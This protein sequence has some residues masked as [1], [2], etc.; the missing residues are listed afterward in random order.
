MNK[1][2]Y[3]QFNYKS[4]GFKIKDKANARPNDD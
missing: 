4:Q 2:N 3:I 1:F